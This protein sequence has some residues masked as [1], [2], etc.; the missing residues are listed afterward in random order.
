MWMP[1]SEWRALIPNPRIGDSDPVPLTL[2]L[3]VLRHHLATERGP[4][5]SQWFTRGT[6]CDGELDWIVEAATS[7]E[8][9]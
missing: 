4:G 7:E 1:E 9:R 6:P 3:R 8:V 5:E 2:K